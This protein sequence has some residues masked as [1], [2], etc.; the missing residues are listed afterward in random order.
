MT[1][2]DIFFITK[3]KLLL[4]SIEGAN[5]E[6]KVLPAPAL[7]YCW[8]DTFFVLHSVLIVSKFVRLFVQTVC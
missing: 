1:E 8:F 4:L 2:N 7:L 6:D 5:F 3:F